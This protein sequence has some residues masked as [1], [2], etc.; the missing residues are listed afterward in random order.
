MIRLPS[1]AREDDYEDQIC[2]ILQSR[3]YYIETRLILKKGTEEVLEF[4]AVATPTSNYKKPKIVEVKSGSWGLSD[5]FKLYGQRLYTSMG[6]GWLI[7]KKAASKK[8]QEAIQEVCSTISV[9]TYNISISTDNDR[10]YEDIP[11]GLDIPQDLASTIF[12]ISWYSRIATRLVRRRFTS[13][14]D[15][16]DELPEPINTVRCYLSDLDNSLFKKTALDRVGALYQSYSKSPKAT[17]SLI[18][19]QKESCSLEN[20]RIFKGVF[21]NSECLHIQY[22]ATIEW[23]A[24]IAIIKN[25][26]DS[27]LSEPDNASNG[28]LE[29][30]WQEHRKSLLPNSFI[31]GLQEMQGFQYANHCPFFFQV[32]IEIFGGFYDPT[33]DRELKLLADATGIPV[34]EIPIAIQLLDIF[35]PIEKGWFLQAEKVCFIKGI[36]AYI[37]GAGCF[38]R[39]DIYGEDWKRSSSIYSMSDWYNALF[40]TVESHLQASA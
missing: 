20:G 34:S 4:D 13:W 10:N 33:D 29:T 14:C 24:R 22:V 28:G 32:F 12:A 31:S 35:F 5:I 38:L 23:R 15:S 11:V 21:D 18:H 3:G 25:A 6:E 39:T 16:F 37:R 17:S 1:E 7:H 36:P 2:S 8:K 40:T 9:S 27:L 30:L 19:Y 26:Y